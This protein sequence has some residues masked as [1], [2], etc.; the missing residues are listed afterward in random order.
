METISWLRQGKCF[1]WGWDE[2]KEMKIMSNSVS[3]GFSFR[4][5]WLGMS[6]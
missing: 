2:D 5:Y 3:I 4:G 1:D 6:W